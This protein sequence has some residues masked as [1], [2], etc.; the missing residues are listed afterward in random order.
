MIR[1]IEHWFLERTKPAFN[2]VEGATAVDMVGKNTAKINEIV[3]LVNNFTT[4]IDNMI[5]EFTESTNKDYEAFKTSVN[6]KI[7]DFIETVDLK[8]DSQDKEIAESI[9]YIKENL[10][11]YIIEN[12]RTAINEMVDNGEL[13]DDI[14][15]VFDSVNETVLEHT[16]KI[17]ELETSVSEHTQQIAELRNSGGAK[18]YNL[19]I[20]GKYSSS[21]AINSTENKTAFNNLINEIVA[22]GVDNGEV[23]VTFTTSDSYSGVYKF[24]GFNSLEQATTSIYLTKIHTYLLNSI[25]SESV[26][27]IGGSCSYNNGLYECSSFKF[28]ENKVLMYKNENTSN[29]I[30]LNYPLGSTVAPNGDNYYT[31]KKYV[32]NAVSGKATVH[33]GTTEPDSSLGS[34][35][36]VYF[37]YD[38]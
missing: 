20:S 15:S 4:E 10:Q 34:N 38:A 24:E 14:M 17:G 8:L 5:K 33:S 21:S 36:D 7:I 13:T 28:Y 19:S 27:S 3:E 12:F 31:N 2:D 25:D 26:V 9:K 32:D 1:K 22:D 30:T 35:G 29:L 6:Q 18:V 37:M 16:T 11:A 23:N